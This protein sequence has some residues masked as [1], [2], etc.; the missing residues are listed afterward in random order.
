M[1]LAGRRN[2]YA[3]ATLAFAITCSA[4]Q[5]SSPAPASQ[6]SPPP[7]PR[8][9]VVLDA[10]HGGDDT[11]SH[12]D[13]G[14][15]EKNV[16]LTFEVRLRSLLSARGF[17]VVTTRE[18]D[19]SVSLDQ[20]AGIANHANAAVCLSLHSSETGAGVHLFTSS[21]SVMPPPP[22][23]ELIAWK[24]A[25]A[26]WINKSLALAGAINSALAHASL[27]VTLGRIPLPAIESMT[28][29]AVAIEVSPRRDAAGKVQVEP[30]NADYDSNVIEALAAAMLEWRSD[31]RFSE[32]RRP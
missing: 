18:A 5:P 25:Q 4:Q 7:T 24:V 31:P 9:V 23:S 20:R 13:S 16:N 32:M 6:P 15:L 3:V 21:L 8:F 2:L 10:A 14:Q 19:T 1:E 27:P 28:C 26:P 22:R 12:L 17:Q 29:P 11:G 30:D